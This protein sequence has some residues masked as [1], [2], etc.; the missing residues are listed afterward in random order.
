MMRGRNWLS[1]DGRGAE[2]EE[3]KKRMTK[4]TGTKQRGCDPVE[5]EDDVVLSQFNPPKEGCDEIMEEHDRDDLVDCS[6]SE[7][8]KDADGKNRSTI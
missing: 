2:T 1:K 6:F 5:E 4:T 3:G 7:K 8:R